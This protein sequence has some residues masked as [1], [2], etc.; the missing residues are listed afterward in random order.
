V[1]HVDGGSEGERLRGLGYAHA[2]DRGLQILMMRVLGQGRAA[3]LL[4]GSDEMVGVDRFFRRMNWTGGTAAQLEKLSERAVRLVDAY[5]EGVN[6]R[7]QRKLPWELRL[8]GVRFEPWTPS[9]CLMLSRMIGYLTLAQSQAEIERLFVEMVQGEV[10]RP[11]LEELFPGLLEGLDEELVRKVRLGERIVPEAVR[12]QSAI[13]RMMASNSWVVAGS[14][15]ASGAPLLSNDPHLEVNRL[16]NVWYEVALRWDTGSAVA[17]SMPGLPALLIGRNAHMAW[18]ATYTFMDAV[19]SWIEDCK[20]GCYRRGEEWV[21]FRERR[22]TILRKGGAPVEVVFHENDHGALDGDPSEPGLYLTTLWSTSS[23]GAASL[24]AAL[25]IPEARTVQ[26][27][28]ALLG[29]VESA[30]NWVL[31]D[32]EGHI[33]YQMSGLMPRRRAGIRGFVPLPGW[34]PANDWQGFVPP[35]ELPRCVDPPEGF[36]ATANQDLNHLGL[37]DPINMPMGPYRAARIAALLADDDQITVERTRRMHMDLVS[38]QAEALMALL[39][40]LLPATPA[41]EELASWD[42]CYDT[43]SRGAA[44][45]EA[46]YSALLVA[47]FGGGDSADRMGGA[48]ARYLDEETG[49][50]V[51]F[52][53]NFDRIL[54]SPESAWFGEES[55]EQIFRRVLEE[56][57]DASAA[58]SGTWGDRQRF[59]MSHMLLGG[60]LPRWLG[61]DRGPYSLIGGRATIHQGQIYRSGGR[62]TSFAPS[63][64]LVVDLAEE[65]AWTA[66]GGGPS[67][68]RFSKWY[69]SG[70]AGWL[71]GELKRV[72]P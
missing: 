2:L 36:I 23:S 43:E 47:V 16:P 55:R 41:A 50:F 20:D 52:Y 67:D 32:G 27:G 18:G 37:A 45:F 65:G 14:R 12:W 33:A 51:D 58:P 25:D 30:W 53:A 42:L 10:P 22:E 4:D 29:R 44:L 26:E 34:D 6:E 54:L 13:P 70:I 24:M 64:R 19:D 48:V 5:C 21:P 8:V 7:L 66:L 15:T 57:L 60:K 17:M 11:L 49:A 71:A 62:V 63:M 3:E 46:V 35:E 31:A 56:T 59:T 38:P 61:F 9:D 68:R 1:I 40:P 39:R 72:L 69:A 28:M